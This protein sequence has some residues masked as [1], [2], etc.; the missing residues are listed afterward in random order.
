MLKWRKNN[1][2]IVLDRKRK[3]YQG[4]KVCLSEG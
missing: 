1:S 3:S 4:D 2:K